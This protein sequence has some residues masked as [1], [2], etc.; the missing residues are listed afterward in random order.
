MALGM[1]V[2][3]IEKLKSLEGIDVNIP[4]GERLDDFF[5]KARIFKA[6]LDGGIHPFVEP[7]EWGRWLDGLLEEVRR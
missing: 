3:S 2:K 4:N 5:E 6:R 1:Y 7:G